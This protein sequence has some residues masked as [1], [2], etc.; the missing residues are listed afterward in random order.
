M[1]HV[2][3]YGNPLLVAIITYLYNCNVITQLQSAQYPQRVGVN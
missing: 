2:K 3:N 1:H